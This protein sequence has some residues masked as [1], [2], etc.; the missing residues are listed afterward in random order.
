LKVFEQRWVDVVRVMGRSRPG[1]RLT[2]ALGVRT[3]HG[4]VAQ[5]EE[6]KTHLEIASRVG[7]QVVAIFTWSSLQPFLDEVN[8]VG[9]LHES[10][11]A[12]VKNMASQRA[13]H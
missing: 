13:D 4:Q 12:A 7:M 9:D 10:E 5:A 2:F 6:T 1:N 11:A 8:R 3:S